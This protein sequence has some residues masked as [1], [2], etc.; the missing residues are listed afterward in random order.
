MQIGHTSNV[1][2]RCTCSSTRST[3]PLW[4]STKRWR[5]SPTSQWLMSRSSTLT[6]GEVFIYFSIQKFNCLWNAEL[7]TPSG[8]RWL[9]TRFWIS[10]TRRWKSSP[11]RQKYFFQI[12]QWQQMIFSCQV[13]G[14]LCPLCSGVEWPAGILLFMTSARKRSYKLSFMS[15]CSGVRQSGCFVSTGDEGGP[16]ECKSSG[17]ASRIKMCWKMLSDIDKLLSLPFK[18]CHNL[19]L[20]SQTINLIWLVFV[21]PQL[22][23]FAKPP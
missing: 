13:C 22:R 14:N 18:S 15:L 17:G 16:W 8:T 19:W 11:S 7:Q 4:I 1:F 3:Q 23:L 5:C 9:S 12:I 2:P 20:I 21:F 6:T 10:S